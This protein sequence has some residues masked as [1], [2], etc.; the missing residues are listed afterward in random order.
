MEAQRYPEDYDGIVA[1]APANYWTALLATAVWTTRALT[2]DAGSF[3]EPAKIPVIAA[4]VDA[5]CD[6]ADGVKDGILGDPRRCRFDPATIQCKSGDS[7]DKCLTAPQVT[8]LRKIYE[9]PRDAQGHQ[10]FPGYLPGAETGDGG[11][12]LWITGSAPNKS[13]LAA[14]GS[15]YF[16]QIVYEKPDWDYRAFRLDADLRAATEK[17]AAALN[18]TDPDLRP[19]SA[20]GGKLI[21]YHGWQDPA[22]PAVN[23]L[24]Y[25][26]S[27]LAR[28]GQ[29]NANAF[30][31]LYM[32]PGM[33]HCGDGP[34]PDAF[35]QAGRWSPKDPARNLGLAL[36]RWVEQGVAPSTIVAAKYEG[37]GPDRRATIS[38]PL[39]PYPQ[40]ARYK[41]AGDLKDAASFACAA[42]R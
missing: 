19:F 17:T 31:R 34:G 27:V 37:D 9:G 1:G 7:G 33:Q 13:L 18:A 35:G 42:P 32:A 38:R 28:M 14:F 41:G 25:Y 40:E 21:L 26:D 10:V 29:R 36:E 5:A 16:S 11:W 6:A 23:T 22:I 8:A 20:R 24:N 4:A 15:G 3:I 39:C 30:V 2:Q 12:T